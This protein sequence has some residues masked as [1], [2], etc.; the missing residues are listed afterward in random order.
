MSDAYYVIKVMEGDTPKYIFNKRTLVEDIS[1]ARK[2]TNLTPAKRY[3]S[4]SLFSDSH[5]SIDLVD[6][7]ES[8]VD[9]QNLGAL[10]E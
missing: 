9:P 7:A 5:L 1:L 10:V 8:P 6:E 4:Q 2:F 3:F